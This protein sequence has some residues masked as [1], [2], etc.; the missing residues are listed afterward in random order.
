MLN[1][2]NT[3]AALLLL[4]VSSVLSETYVGGRMDGGVWTLEG[5]PYIVEGERVRIED[6][7]LVI[8]PG[9]VVMFN[10]F[11][12]LIGID[13][14]L[15]AEGTEEDSIMFIP[16]DSS[17]P[18]SGFGFHG[19]DS[20]ALL[21][22]CYF[23]FTCGHLDGDPVIA[24]PR[25]M[26]A[27]HC[28]FIS[29]DNGIEVR[30]PN[31]IIEDCLFGG[32]H[33]G[34]SVGPDCGEI[35]T[36]IVRRCVFATWR[37]FA[38]YNGRAENCTFLRANFV[39][40]DDRYDC[41]VTNCIFAERSPAIE[42]PPHVTYNCFAT[43]RMTLY[44]LEGVGDWDR[45]NANGDSTDRFGNM[46]MDPCFFGEGLVPGKIKLTADSPCIDAGDPDSPLDPDGT[47]ADIGAFYFHQRDIDVI[48]DT[49]RFGVLHDDPAD[50]VALTICNV[51]LTP[52]HI[53]SQSMEADDSP[54]FIVAGGGEVEIEPESDH[55]TWIAFAPGGR[56]FY[57]G[58]FR[59]AS[60]DPDEEIVDVPLIGVAL[61]V[62]AEH[63]SLPLSF[64]ISSIYPNPFNNVT[65]IIF[66]L[67][68][69]GY[70]ELVVYDLTGR[71]VDVIDRGFK[72]SG[73]YSMSYNASQ[74]PSGVYILSL[75]TTERSS[76]RKMLLIK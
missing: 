38:T 16:A 46:Q 39:T 67:D 29:H 28:S 5:S 59:I 72:Q 71:K 54:F 68:K 57:Q 66:T 6:D 36:T 30:G 75:A 24:G 14:I 31:Y 69:P 43:E 25:R 18:W 21:E 34:W 12:Y 27:R 49:L 40:N 17:M 76:I 11:L 48:P 44:Y 35:D 13:L 47:R 42:G 32:I 50:T 51:G 41:V 15:I 52:L 60:D 8:E 22:Y 2:I 73:C 7:T 74:L 26:E 3:I 33:L 4:T 45:I 62:E 70:I 63:N 64:G 9:V 61:S 10:P 65:G 23:Y 19:D 20:Y 53:T 55:Q 1:R 56:G 58:I 37:G